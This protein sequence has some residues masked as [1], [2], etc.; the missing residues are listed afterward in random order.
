[1]KKKKIFPYLLTIVFT[2]LC[3]FLVLYIFDIRI[4]FS[5]GNGNS[6]ANAQTDIKVNHQQQSIK[7][8]E[9]ESVN[10]YNNNIKSVVNITTVVM[11]Y[12]FFFDVI[13]SEGLGSGSI[14]T[15]DGHVLTNYHV[16][17]DVYESRRGGSITVTL[18]DQTKYEA[19]IIGVDPSTDLAVLKMKTEDTFK[20]IV[21]AH[22]DNI[23]VGQRVY[24]IG[25]PF[26]LAGTLTQGIISSL[27]RTIQAQD[28]TL[29]EDVIQTD[30]AI[31]PG[32]SGGPLLNSHGEMIGVNTSIFTQ[33]SGNIGIGF[34]VSSNTLIK[35][36]EDILEF[37]LVLRPSLGIDNYY[38]LTQVPES[39]KEYLNF[40]DYGIAVIDVITGSDADKAGLRG[41]TEHVRLRLRWNTYE[42]PVGGDII[43]EVD[44]KAVK[45]YNDLKSIIKYKEFG[46][47]IQLTIFRDDQKQKINV[48]L[49]KNTN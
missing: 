39:V 4:D 36:V 12:N 6:I 28:G 49:T 9:K 15:K 22:S 10:L 33:S 1:M 19:D 41:A 43:L 47:T 14:V 34:A 20:P 18:H 13:P 23:Q 29:I 24:A 32:N 46:E 35:V 48:E 21:I 38:L 16:I 42:I 27:G 40:P 44:G 3:I 5:F 25:N 45:T 31:N 11:R 37:G 26:G 8:T 2:I 7:S 17:T 30:A